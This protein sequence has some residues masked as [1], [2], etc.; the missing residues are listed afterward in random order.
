MADIR[1]P[2][3]PPAPAGMPADARVLWTDIV[4]SVSHDYFTAGDLVLLKSLCTAHSQKAVCDRLVSESGP[5]MA[6]GS[7]NPALKLSMGLAGTMASLSAKL[8]LC[9]SA[10]TRAESAQIKKS[11]HGGTAS[12]EDDSV[13]EY[14][15]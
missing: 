8:R 2:K 15:S 14:F 1:S 6:D 12:W 3:R 9:K 11:L 5:V 13:S 10:T 4:A 7:A